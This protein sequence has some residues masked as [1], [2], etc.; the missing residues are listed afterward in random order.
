[1]HTKTRCGV[2]GVGYLGMHHARV[3]KQLPD[4]ELVGIYEIDSTK[5]ATAQKIYN[6]KIFDSLEALG[7]EC[8]VVSVVVPTDKHCEVAC[9]L[10]RAGAHLLI[11]KPLCA[12]LQEAERILQ[13]AKVYDRIVQVGHIEHFNPVI[14]F[15]ESIIHE[16]RFITVDRLAPFNIRGTEVGVVL[17]LM[18]HDI[19]LLLQLID[20]ELT[21]VEAIGVNILS[22]AEDIANARLVFANGCVANLNTS[23]VS[24]KKVREIRVFQSNTYISLDFAA[25]SGHLIRKTNEGIHKEIIPIQQQ[26]PLVIELA[27]FVQCVQKRLQ[28]K[29][30]GQ[31]G[32]RALEIAIE[33]TEQIKASLK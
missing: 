20:S 26:E 16:P 10:L 17:D 11:E 31:L 23:R 19:G 2:A 9:T 21:R 32:R 7:A 27:A 4:C 3:Y 14:E 24:S 18:I 6:C 12:S 5:A 28:P 29:V 30:G 8:E 1:M 22:G 15:L 33:I 13:H 25:Q